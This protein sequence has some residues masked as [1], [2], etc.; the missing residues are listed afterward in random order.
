MLCLEIKKI[1]KSRE[2]MIFFLIMFMAV[3]MDFLVN[4]YNYY[5]AGLSATMS[6]FLMNVMVNISRA[7]FR[8]V[9][10]ML[11]PIVVCLPASCSYLLD[12]KKGINN[13]IFCRINK[14]KYV[15][16]KGISIFIIVFFTMLINIMLSLALGF[17]A[18]PQYGYADYSSVMPLMLTDRAFNSTELLNELKIYHP[19]LNLIVWILFRSLAGGIMALMAYGISFIKYVNQYIVIVSPFLIVN[20]FGTITEKFHGILEEFT[21]G[22]ILLTNPD[23]KWYVYVTEYAVYIFISIILIGWGAKQ[24]EI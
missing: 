13:C 11:L 12:R 23:V 19:Y 5:G 18:F 4:C 15:W 21:F 20:L 7:P 8:L 6:A 3:I 17:I 24:D 16:N 9:Y 2:Y 10:V 14:K 1:I 22:L